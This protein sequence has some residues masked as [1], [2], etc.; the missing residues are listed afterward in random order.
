MPELYDAEN[1][2]FYSD[3]SLVMLGRRA[4]VRIFIV[5]LVAVVL[6]LGLLALW[7]F[8]PSQLQ[9]ALQSAGVRDVRWSE[10]H[11]DWSGI[12]L[13]ELR[14]VFQASDVHVSFAVDRLVI[15][16]TPAT[17]LHA[18]VDELELHG[19]KVAVAVE[20]K[21][22]DSDQSAPF[23]LPRLPFRR[24]S[25][26]DATFHYLGSVQSELHFSKLEI[27]AQSDEL[28]A[29]GSARLIAQGLALESPIEA[30]LTA[31]RLV[32][33]LPAG[34][35][36][37]AT[38][39]KRGAV[40][41]RVGTVT[42]RKDTELEISMSDRR[43]GLVVAA[44]LE[45]RDCSFPTFGMLT[46]R[47]DDLVLE[48]NP[49][50]ITIAA[51]LSAQ[52]DS[53]R[54]VLSAKHDLLSARGSASLE[55][56]A[57]NAAEGLLIKKPLEKYAPTLQ[58]SQGTIEAKGQVAWD[59]AGTKKASVAKTKF[60]F[61]VHDASGSREA[62]VFSGL[63]LKGGGTFADVLSIAP[64]KI[65]L[66][67]LTLGL[68]FRNIE[69]SYQLQTVPNKSKRKPA[70]VEQ[71]LKNCS[72]SVA[73]GRVV[74][75]SGTIRSASPNNT[76]SLRLEALDLQ[77]LLELYPQTSLKATGTIDGEIPLSFG[78]SGIAV[79]DGWIEAQKGGGRIQ[80]Q[81]DD[82]A[83]AQQG[84]SQLSFVADT[85]RNYVYTALRASV[86]YQPEGTLTLGVHIEGRNPDLNNGRQVNVNLNL[87]DNILALL[88]SMRIADDVE[89]Q[90]RVPQ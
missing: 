6:V 39:L 5:F 80:Y 22:A 60:S 13:A 82:G 30:R 84:A 75:P 14:G 32:L 69:C 15:R 36:I 3:E 20:Q 61:F 81:P 55:V 77:T 19:L 9:R 45:L 79:S 17:L 50:L 70:I 59:L 52:N 53:M 41:C 72:A 34:A 10:A 76:L 62:L 2:H 44:A 23:Q 12:S 83:A 24:V 56:P 68:P 78:E 51:G 89:Q 26:Q 49:E 46:L 1:S 28:L 85:L 8:L 64:T 67:E 16:Y 4:L 43:F 31:E 66:E 38:P 74:L 73:G 40:D 63:E 65:L 25:M 18:E 35:R 88:K 90:I 47:S 57:F 37:E 86:A 33:A 58:L 71:G 54:V 7:R 11:V 29:R 42:T 21:T 27:E 48:A 87:E